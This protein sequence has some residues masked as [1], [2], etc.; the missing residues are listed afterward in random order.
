MSTIRANAFLDSAGGNTA[1]INGITPS[2]GGGKLSVFTTGTGATFTPDSKTRSMWIRL[3]GGGGGG[4]GCNATAGNFGGAGG[5]GAYLEE[6]F[7]TIL[8]S[9]TY[10]V[11]ALGTGGAAGANAGSDGGNSTFVAGAITYTAAGGQGGAAGSNNA[12]KTTAGGIATGGDI[13]VPG[14]TGYTDTVFSRGGA[15]AFGRATI[16]IGAGSGSQGLIYG[17]G[18]TG[19]RSAGTS[20]A[21]GNGNAG[22]LIVMEIF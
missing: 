8:A 9:Y 22:V 16:T 2:V 10:T 4:G 15:N 14:E 3:V 19:A 17:G 7:P 5:S 11:G 20:S 6:F 12:V 18:G 13:N 21:G 1:T